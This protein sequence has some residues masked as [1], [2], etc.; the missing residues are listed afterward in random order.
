MGRLGRFGVLGR[1]GEI[2]EIVEIREIRE[3]EA[4]EPVQAAELV[5]ATDGVWGV[6]LWKY[7]WNSAGRQGVDIWVEIGWARLALLVGEGGGGI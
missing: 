3:V 6:G 7:G 1:F 4:A 2:G 5:E